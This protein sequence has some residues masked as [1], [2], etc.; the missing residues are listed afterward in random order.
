VGY[1]PRAQRDVLMALDAGPAV[2]AVESQPM[3]LH[4][5]SEHQDQPA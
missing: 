2:E 3:W 1:E 5:V 4:W